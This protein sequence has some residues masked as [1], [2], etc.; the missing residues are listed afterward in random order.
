[1]VL[2][3]AYICILFILSQSKWD[4][5]CHFLKLILERII[6]L[7]TLHISLDKVARID[8]ITT[9]RKSK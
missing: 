2:N 7:N 1:M 5:F 8:I 6:G 4:T 9:S 3:M